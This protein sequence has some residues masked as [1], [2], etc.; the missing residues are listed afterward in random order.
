MRMITTFFR[1]RLLVFSIVLLWAISA[2]EFLRSE[3]A[4]T[5]VSET[6]GRFANSESAEDAVQRNGPIFENWPKPELAIVISG[7]L[8]G[9]LEPCGCAGLENQKGG[10]KRR[11]TF[12]QQLEADGWPVVSL[13]MGG[14]IHRLGPQSEIKYRYAL[15]ALDKLDYSAVG[16][17]ARELQ[18]DANYLTYVLSNF[19][20]ATNPVV[21]AN[22][23][24][25]DFSIG[26]T[27]RYRVVEAGG[28]KIGVTSVLG[29]K[30]LASLQNATDIHWTEP[31]TA[32]S[33]VLPKLKSEKCDFL[34]LLVH[35][36]PDEATALA[37]QFPEFRIVA[38]TGGADEPP[39]DANSVEG[40][41]T[42]LIEVGHRGMYVVVLGIYDDPQQ[43]FRYQKVPLDHRF[44]DSKEMQAE[45]IAYQD[46]LR[47]LGFDGL[48]ITEMAHPTDRF[49]GS[50]TCAECH[51]EAA[52]VFEETGHAHATE[53]LVNLEPPRHFDPE[54]L[55]CHVTGWNPQEYFP[56]VSGFMG[57][58]KTPHLLGNGCENCHGPGAA[59]V[60][61]EQG[62]EEVS[63]AEIERRRATMRIS[64]VENEGNKEGQKLGVVVDNCLQCHDLDNSP[65]FDFQEYWPEVE[66]YGKD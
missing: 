42:Q 22:V 66:H 18:L 62:D 47:D 45:L 48:G 20:P 25:I 12:L 4:L 8:D 40:L 43:P 65:E 63:D 51:S 55:S 56:Y 33:E 2:A 26:L 3:P 15:K 14:Q 37:K 34:V 10:L 30:H 61:A 46:E 24:V 49:V 21:S 1:Q 23:A 13:D 28:K 35:A 38:T 32:L 29:K 7:E 36:D 6:A 11:Q 59:H 5:V 9:Y 50:E 41:R 57:L 44:E 27:S 60:A 52:E 31:A 39:L 64:L 58:S 19:D 16:L 53:T 17:G 54:C